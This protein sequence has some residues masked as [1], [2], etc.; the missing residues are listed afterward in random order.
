MIE[1]PSSW[2]LPVNSTYRREPVRPL[3]RRQPAFDSEFDA[4]T[5]FYDCFRATATKVMLLGP[6]LNKFP[7]ILD[8]L[9]ITAVPSG[10][11][12]PFQVEHQCTTTFANRQTQSVCRLTVEV[13]EGDSSLQ[14]QSTAGSTLMEIRPRACE[15]F[16]GKR[17]LFTLSKNNDPQWIRDWMRFHRDLHHA[18]AVLLYDNGS[19]NYTPAALLEAMK[20]VSGFS[21]VSVVQWPFKYGPQ[22]VGRGTWDSSYAQVGMMEDARWRFL[23]EAHA[24]LNCDI[25]ELVLSRE[26]DLFDRTA[27]SPSRYLQFSGRWVNMLAD[28]AQ[29]PSTPRHR[30]SV[31][32]SLPQWRWQ[33]LG[34][35]DIKLCPAKWAVVPAHCP[36]N[37]LWSAHEIVGM[38]ANK[39][40]SGDIGYRHFAQISTHW[41][42]QRRAMGPSDLRLHKEDLQLLDAFSKVKWDR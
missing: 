37:A 23:S 7:G 4:L 3:N 24:V 10:T 17:V 22:G 8:S 16:R 18:D 14:L 26:V 1:T 19:T 31:Y 30:E 15:A 39:L 2:V 40:K 35:A 5:V 13:P 32:Q 36:A 9:T 38:R 29:D 33:G 42:K 6:P 21:V 41:K 20:Q 34:P 28:A 12:C 11:K 27:A 25:D